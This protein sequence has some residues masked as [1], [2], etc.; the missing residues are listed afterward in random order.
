MST[1]T[2]T[3]DRLEALLEKATKGV[4]MVATQPPDEHGQPPYGIMRHLGGASIRCEG[5]VQDKS[6][7]DALVELKN[8]APLLL[9]LAR[10]AEA[11][12]VLDEVQKFGE[13]VAT[14]E[15]NVEV[16]GAELEQQWQDFHKEHADAIAAL[17]SARATTDRLAKE[18]QI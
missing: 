11:G 16:S 10:E 4:L 2:Q 3:L 14:L 1:P 13:E 6:L 18:I 8:A 17:E 5:T 9:A 15:I 12:R 7:A